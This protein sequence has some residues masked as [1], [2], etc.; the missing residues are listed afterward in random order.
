MHYQTPALTS[1]LEEIGHKLY[2]LRQLKKEK[3]TSVAAGIGF[4]HAVISKIENGRYLPLSI[5]LLGRLA[6]YYN[7]PLEEL[8]TIKNKKL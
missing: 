5:E 8:L 4:S 6:D 2:D 3:I 7:I 1:I